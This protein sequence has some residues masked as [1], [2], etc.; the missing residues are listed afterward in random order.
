MTNALFIEYPVYRSHSAHNVTLARIQ[1]LNGFSI[2]FFCSHS[3]HNVALA[4]I[5]N[6]SGFSIGIFCSHS[7]HNV[8]LARIQ[9]LNGFSIGFFCSHSAYNVTLARIHRLPTSVGLAQARPNYALATHVLQIS[10]NLSTQKLYYTTA[11]LQYDT[12]PFGL[13]PYQRLQPSTCIF[14]IISASI[15]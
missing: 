10:Y 15:Y 4:R 8:T 13:V 9:N 12:L 1:N 14:Y 2:G 7:A 6:L 11:T 5:Q 3:A